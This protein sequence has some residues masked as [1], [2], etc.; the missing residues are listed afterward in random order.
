TTSI[1]AYAYLA[2]SF[3]RMI[4]CLAS[5][6]MQTNSPVHHEYEPAVRTRVH[7]SDLHDGFASQIGDRA[8]L[9]F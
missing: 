3:S 7:T 1:G 8:F 6:T 5:E 2:S 9:G 4:I